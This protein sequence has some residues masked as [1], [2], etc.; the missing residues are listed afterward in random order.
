MSQLVS[1]M[2]ALSLE[3]SQYQAPFDDIDADLILHT[4]D[5]ARFAVHK[6][7]LTTASSLLKRSLMSGSSSPSPPFEGLVVRREGNRDIIDLAED[8]VTT[9]RV[10]QYCYPISNPILGNLDDVQTVL[11]MMKKF[12]MKCVMN[13]VKSLLVQPSFLEKEPLR[14]FAIAYRFGFEAEARLAARHTLVQPIFGPFVKELEH[15]PASA[16]HKLLQYHR[17]CSVAACS[18]TSDFSWF[19]GFAS[20]WVWFQCDDCVHHHLSWPLSDGKIYEVNAWFIEYMERTRD[21]LRE[22][23][24]GKVVADPM[25]IVEAL[26]TAAGCHTCRAAAYLDLSTFIEEH[27]TGEIE[28]ATEAVDL[29]IHF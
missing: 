10:L 29:D 20:R 15:I 19:P 5:D 25:L 23:P 22:R 14:V 13:R 26:E 24:C 3:V 6:I 27:F 17:K 2:S 21:A 9:E 11:E 16:Y 8:A 4:S 7:F 28:R 1:D 18:L 12:G